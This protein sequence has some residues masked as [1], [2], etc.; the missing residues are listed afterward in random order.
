[1]ATGAP[2]IAV[3]LEGRGFLRAMVRNLV[4]TSVAA[5]LGLVPTTVVRDLL[6]RRER[7]RGVRAPGWGLT[8]MDVS[9]P[10]GTLDWR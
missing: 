7:Y 3:V 4:G 9:Y 2:L 5:G 8:L 6:R 1:V 10:P